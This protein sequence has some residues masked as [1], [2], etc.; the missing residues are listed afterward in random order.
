[1]GRPQQYEVH[2]TTE[3]RNYLM[4]LL[5]GGTQ[6]VKKLKRVQILLKAHDDW[7]DQ[8]IADALNVG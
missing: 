2:L 5:V 6:K 1:M 4:D 3:E 7:T 8:Q